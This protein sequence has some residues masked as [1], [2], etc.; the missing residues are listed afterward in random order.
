MLGDVE[1]TL[2]FYDGLCGLC[3]R[4]VQFLLP[5]DRHE[6]LRFAPLQGALARDEL[7]PHGFDPRDL[8]TVFVIA[9]FGSDRPRVL[10]RSRAVLHAMSRVGGPWGALA[11]LALLV[12]TAVA[13]P[14]YA[15]VARRRYRI[16]GKFDACRLPRPEWRQRFLDG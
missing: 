2:V 5:R 8:D 10:T 12:P 4:F 14:V 11:R 16:F 1:V 6:A 15:W 7:G 13:D 3:D 9:G